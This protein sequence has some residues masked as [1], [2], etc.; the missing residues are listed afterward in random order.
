MGN[1]KEVFFQNNNICQYA[2]NVVRLEN[3]AAQRQPAVVQISAG[4]F[5]YPFTFILD[6]QE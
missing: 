5:N 3:E 4:W 1:I 2:A 6:A